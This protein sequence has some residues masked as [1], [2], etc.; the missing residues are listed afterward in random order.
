MAGFTRKAFFDTK[1]DFAAVVLLNS[2]PDS[3]G[4]ADLLSEHIRQRLAGEPAISLDTVF[5]PAATGVLGVLRWFAAYWIT[6]LAAG[7]F[8]YCCVLCVQGLAAQ[9]LPRRV[10]LRV[11]GILQLGAFCLFVCVYFC[12]RGWVECRD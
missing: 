9:L 7:A 8:T 4:T 2:G 3:L 1:G 5:V 11:S 12:S 10:F 6:M